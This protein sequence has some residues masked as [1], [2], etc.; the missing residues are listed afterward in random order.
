M[1]WRIMRRLEAMLPVSSRSCILTHG[2]V[3]PM[4]DGLAFNSIMIPKATWLKRPFLKEIKRVTWEFE[5][6]QTSRP[7]GFSLALYKV[8]WDIAK[9][10]LMDV[11]VGFL[12]NG[13]LD[14]WSN[15][16]FITLIQKREWTD[17][18]TNFHP[19]SL[20]GSVSKPHFQSSSGQIERCS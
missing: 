15:V 12:R 1:S 14:E 16:T 13:L 7:D 5:D 9:D 6:D 11:I 4:V 18:V 2:V 8:C 17:S 3:K 19:I 20:I 10:G